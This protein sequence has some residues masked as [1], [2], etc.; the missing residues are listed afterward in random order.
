[1]LVRPPEGGVTIPSVVLLKQV[2]SIDKRRDKRRL[3]RRL[4]VLTP[5]TMQRVD[6]AML[7]NLGLVGIYIAVLIYP[8]VLE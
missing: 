6:R 7:I 2:R 8:H 3:V 1:V 5:A 4:G